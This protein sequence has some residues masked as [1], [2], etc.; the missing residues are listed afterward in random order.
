M[1]QPSAKKEAYRSPRANAGFSMLAASSEPSTFPALTAPILQL[2]QNTAPSLVIE[3]AIKH[4][5]GVEFINEKDDPLGSLHFIQHRLQALLECAPELRSSHKRP[6]HPGPPAFAPSGCPPK[7][8]DQSNETPFDLC[9]VRHVHEH[10]TTLY[11]QH[12]CD[13]SCGMHARDTLSLSVGTWVIRLGL[14]A[15][16]LCPPI[17]PSCQRLAR[18]PAPRCSL[19]AAAVSACPRCF[20]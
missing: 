19:C 7:H 13:E 1:S 9:I 6:P 17:S 3:I 20:D 11:R 18:P 14:Q 5:Q 4:T 16:G 15:A 12:A 2:A 8:N 10:K